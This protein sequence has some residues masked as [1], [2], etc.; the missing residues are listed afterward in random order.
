MSGSARDVIGFL[1]KESDRACTAL[2]ISVAAKEAPGLTLL[3]ATHFASAAIN[4]SVRT[5]PN[6]KYGRS[7]AWGR[8]SFAYLR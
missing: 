6:T 7:Y 1:R 3:T 4:I 2:T 8:I 5:K